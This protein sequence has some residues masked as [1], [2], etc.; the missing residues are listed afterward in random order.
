MFLN[1]FLPKRI[2]IIFSEAI[3][4]RKLS[5]YL[6]AMSCNTVLIMEVL[7]YLSKLKFGMDTNGLLMELKLQL[8]PKKFQNNFYRFIKDWEVSLILHI[9]GIHKNSLREFHKSLASNTQ[10][11][12]FEKYWRS[13]NNIPKNH[14]K[15]NRKL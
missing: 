3:R 1:L 5:S 14:N 8:A 12:K 4:C 15:Y 9:F 10:Q 7:F 11:M 2:W 13:Q 6:M